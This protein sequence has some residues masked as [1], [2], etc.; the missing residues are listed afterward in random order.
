MRQSTNACL[1]STSW[2][3][4][5]KMNV[6]QTK[7]CFLRPISIALL[8]FVGLLTS[9]A[10]FAEEK[11]P[12]NS[13]AIKEALIGNSILHPSF[14]C[15]YYK[16]EQTAELTSV[17]GITSQYSWSVAADQYISGGACSSQ[18]CS[19]YKK[20]A[21]IEFKRRDEGYY[22]KTHLVEGNACEQGKFS[23]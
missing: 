18:G 14:G 6:T 11:Q 21:V 19:I 8:G 5:L 7:N 20:G 15:V 17:S 3:S 23:T 4:L 12:L 13:H 22:R 9:T 16:D 10:V 1:I 2:G